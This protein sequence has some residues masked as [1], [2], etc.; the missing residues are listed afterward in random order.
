VVCS[1]CANAR[2][3]VFEFAQQP[4]PGE[5]DVKVRVVVRKESERDDVLLVELKL[6]RIS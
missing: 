6:L 3:G 4:D 2:E 5:N 1:V